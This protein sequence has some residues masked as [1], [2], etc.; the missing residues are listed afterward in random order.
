MTQTMTKSSLHLTTQQLHILKIIYKFRFVTSNLVAKYK[1]VSTSATNK[2]FIILL[3][4]GLIARRFDKTY[5]LL[6]KSARY[7][8]APKALKLL[9]TEYGLNEQVLHA[10]YKDKSVGEPFVE[11]TLEIM[12]ACLNIR[13]AYPDTFTLFTKAELAK[14]D[15]FP[16]PL[17]DL[18]LLLNKSSDRK[19][20]EYFIDIFS[21]GTLLFIIKKRIDQYID[22][23]ESGDWENN[24]YPLILLICPD[25][26]TGH[27]LQKYIETTFDNKYIDETELTFLTGTDLNELLNTTLKVTE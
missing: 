7:Y 14:H 24:Q 4:R 23:F 3:Q 21:T 17:P 15:Y 8:L 26:R 11:H 9:K 19:T 2:A 22:H 27:K 5:K 10:R 16:Q 1:G 6:G 20:N 13:T 18:Y 12:T 25:N